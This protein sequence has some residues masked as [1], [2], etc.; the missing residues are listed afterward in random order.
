VLAET[1]RRERA[2]VTEKSRHP[3]EVLIEIRRE[4]RFV[5]VIAIDP[6]TRTEVT[7]MGAPGYDIDTLKRLAAHKLG[8]VLAKRNKT[9]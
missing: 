3:S 2:L 9:P 5:R 4:G 6:V 1:R 7:M 8:Y